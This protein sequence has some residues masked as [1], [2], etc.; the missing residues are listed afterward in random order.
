MPPALASSYCG[1][2]T[3]CTVATNWS[4]KRCLNATSSTITIDLSPPVLAIGLLEIEAEGA[5]ANI[6]IKVRVACSDLGS[7]VSRA[8][9]SLGTALDSSKFVRDLPLGTS[10]GNASGSGASASGASGSGGAAF[11]LDWQNT[12]GFEGIVELDSASFTEQ[13][14]EG[15]VIFAYLTAANGAQQWTSVL[16]P[17]IIYDSQPPVVGQ[18]D[19]PGYFWSQDEMAWLGLLHSNDVPLDLIVAWTAASDAGQGVDRYELCLG[20]ALGNCSLSQQTLSA[21]TVSAVVTLYPNEAD[22]L[23]GL[24]AGGLPLAFYVSL[25]AV[26]LVGFSSE[27]TA[28]LLFNPPPE[29]GSIVILEGDLTTATELQLDII[30]GALTSFG[31]TTARLLLWRSARAQRA[32]SAP[33]TVSFL[34]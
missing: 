33:P 17:D 8:W 25:V 18:I 6:T 11:E 31:T 24:K 22:A 34:N 4:P 26:D 21:L 29:V 15:E 23:T 5:G 28:Q 14:P 2:V 16:T 10:S 20:I 1:M 30:G 27:T 9:L 32:V 12:T 3:A 19:L 7:G 13:V